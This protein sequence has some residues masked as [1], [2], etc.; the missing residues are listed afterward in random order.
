MSLLFI[1]YIKQTYSCSYRYADSLRRRSDKYVNDSP[2]IRVDGIFGQLV[3][4]WSHYV[5]WH[6]LKVLR[7]YKIDTLVVSGAKDVM[8]GCW[9]SRLLSENLCA[10]WLHFPDA[11]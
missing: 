7:S 6:R 11:G 10:K 4:A 9:N 1:F 2:E 3:A 8:V 5:S